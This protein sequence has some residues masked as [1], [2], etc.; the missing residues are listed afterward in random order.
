MK[1]ND[2]METNQPNLDQADKDQKISWLL[3]RLY[4]LQV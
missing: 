4:Q 2:R 1:S 3:S